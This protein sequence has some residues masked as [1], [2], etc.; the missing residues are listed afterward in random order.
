MDTSAVHRYL[1]QHQQDSLDTLFTLLRQPSISAQDTGVK[2]CAELLAGLM[3]ARGIETEIVPTPTQPVVFGR[4]D[5]GDPKAFTLI[6]YGHYDVQPPEPLELWK[7]PPFEPTV[8]DGVIYGRGTGDNKGQLIAHVLAAQAW[9]QA[10]GR[11]PINLRFVFEGEE[12]S[13]SRSLGWFVEH[14]QERL[15]ADLVYVSD[16]GLHASGR[17]VISLGNRGI[18]GITL[19]AR[20]ADRDNHS[21]NKGGVAPNPV[22]ML[23]HVL[24]SMVDADGHVKVEGF[25]DGVRPVG[26]VEKAMLAELDYDPVALGATMGLPRV[27]MDAETYYRRIMLEPYFNISGIASGYVGQGSKTIIPASAEC[28]I[29]IRLVADQDCEDVL[30]KVRRHVAA[31]DP[32]VEVQARGFGTMQPHRTSPGHPALPA[33]KRA[34]EAV[35]GVAPLVMPCTG[36]SLPNA[37][38]PR[39]LGAAVLDVP[40]ANADEN[41]HAPNENITVERFLNG[42]H[43]SAQVFAELAG[44]AAGAAR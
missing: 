4:L 25:Y 18:Q 32:G 43:V 40:Y 20:G 11:V 17:P 7:S 26:D 12:E 23:V 3:R 2:Q 21:G 27:E 37:V 22:W 41:N 36:G 10:A 44:M 15:K 31:L 42:P 6:C 8:R 34:I 16:G 1:D 14:H 30:A 39:L 33:V 29:D 9:L 19:V 5:C 13:G 35:R 28:R 24:A 38:W